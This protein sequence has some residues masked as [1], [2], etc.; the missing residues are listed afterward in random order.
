RVGVEDGFFELGGD[1][2]S[3]MQLASRARQAGL[4]LTPRQVFE[5]KTAERLAMVAE[6]AESDAAPVADVGTGVVPWTPVMRALGER[7]A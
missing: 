6:T 5:E 3:S 4:I 7:A 1:S 2:I